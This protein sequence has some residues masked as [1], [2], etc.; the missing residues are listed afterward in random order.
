[1]VGVDSFLDWAAVELRRLHALVRVVENGGTPEPAELVPRITPTEIRST[2]FN[3]TRFF[4][5]YRDSE[6]DDFLRIVERE[7]GNLHTFFSAVSAAALA[8][9]PGDDSRRAAAVRY[10]GGPGFFHPGATGAEAAAKTFTRTRFRAG[11]DTAQVDAF[12][13]RVGQALDRLQAMAEP[14]RDGRP[15]DAASATAA[16]AT[17]GLTPRDIVDARFDT[18]WLTGGYSEYEVDDFLDFL[19]HELTRVQTYLSRTPS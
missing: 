1:M 4:S 5:G 6:V 14:A 3:T 17:A 16:S 7:F 9:A 15:V 8:D 19:E 18:T 12:L 2:R 11:Y 13:G 10:R